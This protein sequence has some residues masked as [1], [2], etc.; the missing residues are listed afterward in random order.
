M[1]PQADAQTKP[2]E[3][4]KD[5]QQRIWL[6]GLVLVRGRREPIEGAGVFLR[7]LRSGTY[8]DER[9]SYRIALRPGRYTLLIKAI[10]Y[11]TLRQQIDLQKTE[12]RNF[13]LDI[14]PQNPFQTVVRA[15]RDKTTPGQVAISRQEIGTMPGGLGRDSFRA[16]QN[17]PGVAQGVGLSGSLRIR[18]AA[19]ADTGFYLDG[20]RIPLLY[21]FSGGPSVIND[22]FIDQIDFYPG[23]APASFGRLTAG[24]ISVS[25]R[26]PSTKAIHGEVYIDIIHAGLFLEVPISK[27]LGIAVAARRS[28]VDAFIPL[29]TAD[30]LSGRYW[31]YQLKLSWNYGSHKLSLFVFGADD[32]VDYKGRT[33]GDSLP[34]ISDDPFF[35][36]LRFARAILHYSLHKDPIRFQF[37]VA[38]GFDNSETSSPG[39]SGKLWL[40]PIAVRAE[41]ELKLHK[42]LSISAGFDGGWQR[43]YY[44]FEFLAREFLGFPSP[45]AQAVI[46]TGDGHKDLFFPGA[47]IG[48][49]W[50][51]HQDLSLILG[52]RSDLYHLQDK[53]F[54]SADPRLSL[55]W[56][57]NQW[58][59]AL[60]ATGLF[61]R[62]PQIEEWSEELGNPNLGLQAAW[63]LAMGAEFFPHKQLSIRAQYFYSYM[64]DRIVSS[65]RAIEVDGQL[66]RENYNNEGLGR[67]YGLEI[68]IR[69]REFYSLSAWLAYTFSRAERGSIQAGINQLYNYDQ[70]HILSLILQ[71]DLGRGWNIG[72]RFRLVS[73]RPF[74]PIIG[75]RFDTDTDSYRPV[76]GATDSARYP[77][78]HQLD[79]RIDKVWTFN[80]WKLG[81]YLDLINAYYAQNP[82][83]YRYQYDYAKA[84]PITNLPI[85]PAF[86][87]RGEF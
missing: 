74:T 77:I 4:R 51:P 3:H 10:G 24:L 79:L 31:D 30:A 42:K 58:V 15:T 71:Y 32:V 23:A 39:Q 59:T 76:R 65:S 84:F 78:F 64:F 29:I 40:W 25:S 63:Q 85:V 2:S 60:M 43:Q 44:D 66:K 20:H 46:L 14:D 47:Y 50:M 80:Y 11:L 5:K 34:F 72:L 55:R 73:G 1:G 12:K 9:G 48:I 6:E 69:L 87:V 83:R 19:P 41:L 86:G 33:Q 36:A 18:G 17:L 52:L 13:Y 49:T 56:R 38:S 28:Y 68:L 22:R 37:S 35:L 61:H 8:S 54:W 21:H 16:L 75:S 7:E 81:I 53:L 62:P 45:D 70:P 67:A 57:I 26:E 27:Y 82:E